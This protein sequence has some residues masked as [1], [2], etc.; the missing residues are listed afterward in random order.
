MSNRKHDNLKYIIICFAI[1][2]VGL[3]LFLCVGKP[4]MDIFKADFIYACVNGTEKNN[5]SVK[6]TVPEISNVSDGTIDEKEWHEPI[7]GEQYGNILCKEAGLNAPLYVGDSDEILLK[8]A[9]QSLLSDFPGKGGTVLVGGH[10]TTFFAALEKCS[11]G[12]VITLT[13][14]YGLYEYKISDISIISG[15]NYNIPEI[16]NNE[17]LVL[18][19]CYPFGDTKSIREQKILYTCDFIKGPAIGGVVR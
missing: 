2:I 11:I 19:T 13:C 4:V 17:K 14:T 9:G 1:F 18:Y 6:D 10:D 5:F 8:G 7:Y 3:V 15:S 16:V 12:D